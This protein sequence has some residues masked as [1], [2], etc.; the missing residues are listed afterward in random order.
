MEDLLK[1]LESKTKKDSKKE[2]LGIIKHHMDII[3]HTAAMLMTAEEM[4]QEEVDKYISDTAKESQEKFYSMDI[5]DLAFYSVQ[6][7]VEYEKTMK[8]KE[9]KSNGK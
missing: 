2:G 1:E 8:E 3:F 6:K 7:L 4:A 9:N 5:I